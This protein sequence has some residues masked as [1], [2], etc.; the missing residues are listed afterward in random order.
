MIIVPNNESRLT[1]SLYLFTIHSPYLQPALNLGC[2]AAIFGEKVY[3]N[4]LHEQT[5]LQTQHK[6]MATTA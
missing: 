6:I 4:P 5:P 3:A 1:L 2:Y